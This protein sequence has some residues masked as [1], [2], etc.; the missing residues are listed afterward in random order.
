MTGFRIRTSAA[1]AVSL[2]SLASALGSPAHAGVITYQASGSDNDG[3]LAG[4]ATFTTKT[5]EIDITLT[6][7]MAASLFKDQGQAL[8]G[9]SFTLSNAPGT[10]GAL[11]VS[12]Q[13]ADINSSTG[14]VTY[15]SG[16]PLRWIGEGPK[17]GTGTFSV[18]GNTITLESVGGGQPSEMITPMIGNGSSFNGPVGGIDNFNPYTIGTVNIALVF[19]GVTS[20]TTVTAANFAFGTGPDIT[21]PGTPRRVPEPLTLSLFGA[22]VVGVTALRRRKRA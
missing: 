5:N 6:D 19:M 17:G 12:G 4:S 14:V 8:S 10:E 16:E 11:S 7:T 9:L 22:G 15:I 21:L 2:A 13:L 1:L 18:S 3:A 20:A